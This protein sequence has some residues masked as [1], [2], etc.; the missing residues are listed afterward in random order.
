MDIFLK[1]ITTEPVKKFV[2]E[3]NDHRMKRILMT[4]TVVT[5]VLKIF[6]QW[7]PLRKLKENW[8]KRK[9]ILLNNAPLENLTTKKKSTGP[10]LYYD[11]YGSYDYPKNF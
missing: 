4:S 9:K 8:K 5:I 6:F 1:I 7:N 3:E 10:N 11:G 2:N